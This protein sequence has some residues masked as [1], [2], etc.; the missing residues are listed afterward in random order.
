[1]SLMNWRLPFHS[2]YVAMLY[3]LKQH[4]A[5][6]S[7]LFANVISVQMFT[8]LKSR[9]KAFCSSGKKRLHVS[10]NTMNGQPVSNGN[11]KINSHK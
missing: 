2:L 1:M 9:P 10:S 11:S 7:S 4:T 6:R 5:V 3:E 8:L